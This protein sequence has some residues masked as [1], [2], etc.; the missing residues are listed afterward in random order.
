M[1]MTHVYMAVLRHYLVAKT[2]VGTA[3]MWRNSNS[4]FSRR[5]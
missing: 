4:C 2:S 5:T 1:E 3:H